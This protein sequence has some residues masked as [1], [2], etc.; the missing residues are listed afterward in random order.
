MVGLG[1]G[2]GN[3]GRDHP[4]AALA[5]MGERIALEMHSAALPGG[6]QH[7]RRGRLDA[8]VRIADHQLHAGDAAAD[9]IA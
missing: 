3:R 9:K 1:K 8:L 2:R 5:G 7:P 6:G 4:A